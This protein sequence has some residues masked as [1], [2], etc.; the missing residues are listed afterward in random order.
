ME[1]YKVV[2]VENN[3]RMSACV[4]PHILRDIYRLEYKQNEW[5]KPKIEG[6][7]LFCFSNLESAENFFNGYPEEHKAE[8][9]KC[10]IK[11]GRTPPNYVGKGQVE[12]YWQGI[13]KLIPKKKKLS[14]LRLY[15]YISGKNLGMATPD[16]TILA[17]EIKLIEKVK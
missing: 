17:K 7:Y 1:Y 14:C 3:K 2:V 10:E 13:G 4:N 11:G 15:N 8:I 5:T 12:L 9:W 16:Y 6:S